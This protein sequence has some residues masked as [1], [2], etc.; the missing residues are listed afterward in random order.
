MSTFYMWSDKYQPQSL[1]ECI[2][3]GFPAHVQ[4]TLKALDTANAVPNMLL[5][6]I[7]GTGKSTV[8]RI[9]AQRDGYHVV[10]KN[11]SLLNK[12]NVKDLLPTL[13]NRSL[14]GDRRLIFI[15]EADGMT[16][17]AQ[18][19]LRSLIDPRYEASWLMTCNFRKKL[20]E[21]IQS[22]FMQI[23]CSLPPASERPSHVSGIVRRCQQIL[24]DKN[25]TSVSDEDLA[26]IA[27][28]KYPDIRQTINEVQLRY[29]HLSQQ[30]AA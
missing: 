19:A 21:P 12:E 4:K 6:G 1:D 2:L 30:S 11:G 15:D 5:Y 29:A 14:Y 23:E 13:T 10:W 24:H 3:E 22:R 8:A 9:L 18:L 27:N 28:E 26:K 20:I 16:Q 17:Q 25:I 7:A